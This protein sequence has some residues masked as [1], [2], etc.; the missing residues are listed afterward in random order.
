MDDAFQFVID[1]NGLCLETGYPYVANQNQC[2]ETCNNLIQI[3]NY[4][5]VPPNNETI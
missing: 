1:N 4:S 5:N 2:N 3:S